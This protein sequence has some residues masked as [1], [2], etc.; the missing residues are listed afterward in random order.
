MIQRTFFSLTYLLGTLFSVSAESEWVSAFDGTNLGQLETAG[1]WTI[2]EDGSLY[3]KPREGE[4]GWKRYD[5]YL[6][7][8][9]SYADFEVEFE[10]KHGEGGNSGFYFRISD[11]TDPTTHGFEVQILDCY[12]KEELGKHDLGGVIKTAGPLVNASLPAGE[13][14]KMHV[15]LVGSMLTVRLND[16]LVQDGLD[17]AAAKPEGK[18]LV[19]EGRIAIQDHGQEFWVRNIRVRRH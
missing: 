15:T 8:P 10:Y 3:L 1:N 12:G 18:T 16:Q 13:W 5:A 9:G 4:S 2:Q 11:E 14:N 6:W 7:L 19:S 17:L